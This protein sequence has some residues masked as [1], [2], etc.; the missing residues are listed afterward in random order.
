MDAK[1][2]NS[3]SYIG[4]SGNW[5]GCSNTDYLRNADSGVGA[6]NG[7]RR[8]REKDWPAVREV[9]FGASRSEQLWAKVQ[10]GTKEVIQ[11]AT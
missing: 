8:D 7:V 3:G 9:P 1:A 4:V 10:S 5:S 2:E 6:G 11:H